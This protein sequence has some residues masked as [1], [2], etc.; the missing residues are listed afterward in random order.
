MSFPT[1]LLYVFHKLP[2]VSYMST[3]LTNYKP[4]HDLMFFVLLG[5]I[6]SSQHL[7]QRP[8]ILTSVLM[9]CVSPSWQMMR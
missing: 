8:A 1:S 6:Y 7:A 2:Y 4:L 9:V 3:Q 5:A